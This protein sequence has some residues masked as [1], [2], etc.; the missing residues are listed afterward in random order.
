MR[1]EY[2]RKFAGIWIP[3]H[4][5]LRKDL[6]ANEK[7]LLAE[8][9]SLDNERKGCYASNEYF[10]DLLGVSISRIEQIIAQLRKKNLIKTVFFNGRKRGLKCIPFSNFNHS[11]MEQTHNKLWVRP[12]INYGCEEVKNNHKSLNN[13][14]L[15][16]SNPLRY[17]SIYNIN[18]N[19]NKINKKFSFLNLFPE[20]FKQNETFQ[21]IWNEWEQHRKER[22][23]SLTKTSV[24]RQVNLLTKY[25][26]QEAIDCIT[27]SITMGYIGLFPPKKDIQL[28]NFVNKNPLYLVLKKITGISYDS[29]DWE[30]L[31]SEYKEFF[32]LLE[33]KLKGRY[34]EFLDERFSNCDEMIKRFSDFITEEYSSFQE[35]KPIMLKPSGKM[36]QKFLIKEFH[37][38]NIPISLL[39]KI[40]S[41]INGTIYQE[42]N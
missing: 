42:K 32:I 6:C 10:A 4:I 14:D 5:W 37:K 1:T 40:R 29:F 19:I 17:N 34:K 18:N 8:I 22:K 16:N 11:I 30:K 35:M 12:I 21:K 26:I 25:S 20:H 33:N 15:E 28:K 36:F 27:H 2:Q 9:D 41:N 39:E 24:T 7:F 3:A 13:N 38:N 31:F 23:H